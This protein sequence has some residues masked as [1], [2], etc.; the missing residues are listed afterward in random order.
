MARA[1]A[2]STSVVFSAIDYNGNEYQHLVKPIAVSPDGTQLIVV[3]PDDAMT[4]T[5][6][7]VGEP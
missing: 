6:G 2:C 7:V 1:S 4:G 5:V 3:V